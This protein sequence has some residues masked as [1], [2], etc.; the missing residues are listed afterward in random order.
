MT[1][2]NYQ[3]IKDTGLKSFDSLQNVDETQRSVLYQYINIQYQR[4]DQ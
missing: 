4:I 1:L 2:Q 3:K